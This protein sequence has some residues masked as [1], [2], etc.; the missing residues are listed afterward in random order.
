MRI[1]YQKN[2]LKEKDLPS[3]ITHLDADSVKTVNPTMGSVQTLLK[4]APSVTA[5]SQGPGQSAPTLAI[6][7]VKNDELAET[8]D[9]V[10]I[11]SFLG[12]TGDYLSNNIGSPVTLP[13]IA[14]A[15]VYPGVAPPER[16]GFGTVGG[17]IAYETKQATNKPY[18]ELEGGYGSFDTSHIGFTINTGKWYNDVDAPKTLLLFDQSQTAGYVANTPAQ[19]HSF[20]FNTIKPF[21]DG[22]T[23]VG[24]TIIFNQG[25]GSI[26]T[27]PTPV[28]LQ[29]QYGWNYN[30][31][32]SEGFYNQ[33]GKFLTTILNDKSYINQYLDFQGAV[34]YSHSSSTA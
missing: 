34:F 27:T 19:Y 3:S 15:T 32:R 31:P 24:L 23:Q 14:S 33:T 4:Q 8:L 9:G 1:R 11:S 21:D 5:Y 30:F 6:R 22:L 12:G 17:T 20:L 2:L 7:G 25:K 18:A 10:P 26:Q 16:Q 28:A 29:Q 13:E